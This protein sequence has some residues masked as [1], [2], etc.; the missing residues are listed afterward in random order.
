MNIMNINDDSE[1]RTYYF[2]IEHTKIKDK[3]R[4]IKNIV[5]PTFREVNK[6]PPQDKVL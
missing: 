5:I 2:Y 6:L 3:A 4:I 1:I